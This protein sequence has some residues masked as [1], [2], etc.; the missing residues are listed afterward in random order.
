[1]CPACVRKIEERRD[2]V[3]RSRSNAE[4]AK[5][6]LKAK[7]K[8]LQECARQL[9]TE[10]NDKRR[11]C[12]AADVL[13]AERLQVIGAL[14]RKLQEGDRAHLELL[15]NSKTAVD[16]AVA[17]VNK[18]RDKEVRALSSMI[19]DQKEEIDRF[20]GD[21]LKRA[22]KVFKSRQEET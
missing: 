10:V 8:D 6:R 22:P 16:D 21:H 20:V 1:M 2:E 18:E 9:R 3:D 15:A 13:A 7:I 11:A 17:E 19:D 5:Q 12:R 14:E 4:A